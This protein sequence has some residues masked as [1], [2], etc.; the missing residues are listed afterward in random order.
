MA[1]AYG[2]LTAM[3]D[4]TQVAG[5]REIPPFPWSMLRTLIMLGGEYAGNTKANPVTMGTRNILDIRW[6][7]LE[8]PERAAVGTALA[9][10]F[11]ESHR[12]RDITAAHFNVLMATEA[13]LVPRPDPKGVMR[14]CI[15]NADHPNAV[16]PDHEAAVLFHISPDRVPRYRREAKRAVEIEWEYLHSGW[17]Q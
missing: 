2:R 3:A 12:S 1:V 6:Q 16:V 14:W 8:H 4:E 11:H 5:A 9:R 13:G 15:Y 7:S 17:E 10:A